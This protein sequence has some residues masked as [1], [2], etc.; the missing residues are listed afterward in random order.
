MF[1]NI[2]VLECVEDLSSD[3]HNDVEVKVK[4]I[5]RSKKTAQLVWVDH[6]GKWVKKKVLPP[7]KC[8]T[9]KSYESNCWV[10]HEVQDESEVLYLN[11]GYFY[12]P[13]KT[14]LSKERVIITQGRLYT[15]YT[16][17]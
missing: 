8:F 4:F 14:R 3:K 10:A 16:F 7:G 2:Y 6:K 15:K 1:M 11:Y 9:T 13:W 12:S 5:N 17:T